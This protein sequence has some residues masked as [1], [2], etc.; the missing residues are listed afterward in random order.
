M[1]KLTCDQIKFLRTDSF[2]SELVELQSCHL[3]I[4]TSA[5]V[6]DVTTCFRTSSVLIL[7][8]RVAPTSHVSL[9]VF[10]SWMTNSANDIL[11]HAV[12][13]RGLLLP[14]L[15]LSAPAFWCI[16]TNIKSLNIIIRFVVFTE[17]IVTP[18]LL[19]ASCRWYIRFCIL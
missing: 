8:V 10:R 15:S 3:D 18:S 4:V 13:G 6:L 2:V 14:G 16:L 9:F 5:Y 12:F 1:T 7:Q 19:V 11:C 17:D